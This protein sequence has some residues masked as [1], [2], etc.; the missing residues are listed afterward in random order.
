M[1]R[2]GEGTLQGTHIE[3]LYNGATPWAHTFG[4]ELDR[5]GLLME[6]H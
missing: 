2:S 4:A 5:G 3:T 1:P 6:L